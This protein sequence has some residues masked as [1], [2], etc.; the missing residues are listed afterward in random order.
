MVAVVDGMS[1]IPSANPGTHHLLGRETFIAPVYNGKINTWPV[2]NGDETITLQTNATLPQQP[3]ESKLRTTFN[4]E[5]LGPFYGRK[6]EAISLF[7]E[8]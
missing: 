1:R 6:E 7:W 8:R 5:K 4:T 2:V 3:F